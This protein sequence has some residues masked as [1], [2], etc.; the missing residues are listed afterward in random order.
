MA[1]QQFDLKTRVQLAAGNPASLTYDQWNYYH[2][3]VMGAYGPAFEAV[4]GG[5]PRDTALTLD[6]FWAKVYGSAD[7]VKGTSATSN[8]KASGWIQGLLVGLG[9]VG[10]AAVTGQI[11]GLNQVIPQKWGWVIPVATMVLQGFH[12][13]RNLD[14]NPNG[15][16]AALPFVRGPQ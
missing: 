12:G 7:A 1:D 16:P 14:Y 8:K 2:Q 6:Q 10:V 5:A 15:T 11:P 13:Q 9:G 3:L 4:M